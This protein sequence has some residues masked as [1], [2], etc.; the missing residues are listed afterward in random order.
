MQESRRAISLIP[1]SVLPVRAKTSF[2][3]VKKGAPVAG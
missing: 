3:T 2:L 1:I